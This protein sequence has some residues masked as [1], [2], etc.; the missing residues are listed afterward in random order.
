ML[1]PQTPARSIVQNR[2]NY[3]STSGVR[4]P[5]QAA[6]RK[7]MQLGDALRDF[8]VLLTGGTDQPLSLFDKACLHRWNKRWPA[9]T[10]SSV[11]RQELQKYFNELTH[12]GASRSDI[13]AEKSL[14][15]SFYRWA[16]RC[17]WTT[18]DPTSILDRTRALPRAKAI[19]WV[20][21]E[22]RRLLDACRQS[23]G[24]LRPLVLLG[25]RTGLRLGHLLN[26]EWRHVD[27]TQGR[28]VIPPDE[29]A[30]G[31]IIAISMDI[32]TRG[33]LV[34]LIQKACLTG[35]LPRRVFDVAGL[36]IWNGRP[37]HHAV[38]SAF[39]TARRRAGIPEGDFDSL[40]LTFARNCA[41]ACVPI[42][43]PLR[44]GD[45]DDPTLVQKVYEEHSGPGSLHLFR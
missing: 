30:S 23:P 16:T 45:W 29:V 12:R 2:H 21:V 27:L 33:V 1:N 36:P 32:D 38:L 24:Y 4:A 34:Q 26:L 28:I 8:S 13:L 5:A 44:I 39:R 9:C 37:E 31:G 22:Q 25:L 40:R 42:S 18:V 17:G 15:R 20:S 11:T 3:R 19:Y 14:L 10:L 41:K 6:S 43:Y 35:S 7:G